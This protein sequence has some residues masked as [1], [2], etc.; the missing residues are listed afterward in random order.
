MYLEKVNY[1]IVLKYSQIEKNIK[2]QN[3]TF[4]FGN[5]MI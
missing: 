3:K 1:T 5:N 4:F 2:I